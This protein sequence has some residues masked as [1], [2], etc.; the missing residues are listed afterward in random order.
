M[1]LFDMKEVQLQELEQWYDK[2]IKNRFKKE[3]KVLKQLFDQ[4]QR[5]IAETI[6]ALKSWTQPRQAKKNQPA[7]E[8]LDE[9][10]QEV[11]L[12]FIERLTQTLT[13][14]KIPGVHTEI[15]FES[16]T[17]FLTAIRNL[18][19]I[20]N[21]TGKRSI[22]KFQKQ[23]NIEIRELDMHLRKIGELAQ[24]VEVFL[25]KNYQEGKNAEVLV[26]KMPRLQVNIEKI[27][28]TKTQIAEMETQFKTLSETVTG[29]EN[30]LI[31]I[32]QDP[33]LIQ[34][35]DLERKDKERCAALDE[36]L[37]FK[38]ALKKL[39]KLMEKGRFLRQDI[40][41][42]TLRVYIKDPVEA[43][44]REGAN[45]NDLRDLLIKLRIILEDE[46]DPLELKGEL[47]TKISDNINQI[48]NENY[49]R[50]YI[51]ELNKIRSERKK[52]GEELA[53]KGLEVKRAELKEKLSLMT[54]ER[55]HFEND[56]NRR[57]REY[58]EMIEKVSVEREELQ[59]AVLEQ[60][61]EEVK[62]KVV[63]PT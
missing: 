20:Y 57:K 43:I 16:S 5:E 11:L 45:L 52:L 4:V 19:S 22:P 18:Y 55:E 21:E 61:G 39:K 40:N 8:P 44:M 59:K 29:I 50:P 54:Q 3:H 14:M 35:E 28:Q 62:I 38:K 48:V 37:K 12:R 41:E 58:R 23:Y 30:E 63:I 53:Q 24:K 13:E 17:D 2:Q 32:S 42:D 27:G 34:A 10:S 51:E 56:L 6:N 31:A 9:R 36:E 15:S 26:K 46:S 47:K 33:L 49:L 25:R 7:I 60:T 1:K